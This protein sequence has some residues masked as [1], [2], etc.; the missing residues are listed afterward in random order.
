[1]T[2]LNATPKETRYVSNIDYFGPP[3]Y[4]YSLKQGIRDGFLAPYKVVKV[5]IDRD[6]E[7]YRPEKGQ[8]DREG[9]EVEDR[10]DNTTDFDRTL[11]LDGQAA[12]Y[13]DGVGR[14][15]RRAGV[16]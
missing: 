1:M 15:Y 6:V 11:L 10:I 16:L 8:L 14:I 7:G 4:L 9:Q 5:H 13:L 2:T 12:F 3:V